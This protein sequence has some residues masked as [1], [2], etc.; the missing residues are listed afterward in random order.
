M[1]LNFILLSMRDEL[2]KATPPPIKNKQCIAHTGVEICN[3]Y[4]IHGRIFAGLI[5]PHHS[6]Y[7]PR[8]ST[9]FSAKMHPNS[10]NYLSHTFYIIF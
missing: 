7:V 2:D 3:A 5:P 9:S 1:L 10:K 4:F 8:N 6:Q